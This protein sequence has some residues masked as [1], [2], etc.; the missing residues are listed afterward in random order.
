MSHVVMGLNEMNKPDKH[1][2][3]QSNDKLTFG[4]SKEDHGA[5]FVLCKDVKPTHVKVCDKINSIME[6]VS[7]E[8]NPREGD[9]YKGNKDLNPFENCRKSVEPNSMDNS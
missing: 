6:R 3:R 2:G 4:P 7:P 5:Q 8:K 9:E 1:K